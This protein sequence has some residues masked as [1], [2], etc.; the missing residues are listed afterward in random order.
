MGGVRVDGNHG[1]DMRRAGLSQSRAYAV[2]HESS[3]PTWGNRAETL[4]AVGARRG[5]SSENQKH[6]PKVTEQIESTWPGSLRLKELKTFPW[7][8]RASRGSASEE[9]EPSS[10]PLW[11]EAGF[12]ASCGQGLPAMSG[13]CGLWVDA[14]W[15]CGQAHGDRVGSWLGFLF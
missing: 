5:Q 2:F 14:G 12:S 10:L 11:K 4:M 8:Q 7:G 15:P 3:W 6:L 13:A 9:P 1:D